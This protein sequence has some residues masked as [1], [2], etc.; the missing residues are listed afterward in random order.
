MTHTP[1]LLP[2]QTLAAFCERWQIRELALFGSVLR[3]D[4]HAKSDIDFLVTFTDDA[5]WGLLDHMQMQHELEG[6]LQ[7]PVDFISRR[8]VEQS[9]NWLRREA[10]LSTAQ[11]LYP[12]GVGDHAA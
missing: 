8:A 1:L 10:I 3:D 12:Q 2:D 9:A 7:R 5:P 11:I 4:F 6:L